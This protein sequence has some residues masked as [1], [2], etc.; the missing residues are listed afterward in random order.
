MQS[1]SSDSEPMLEK[2]KFNLYSALYHSIMA[3]NLI[4]DEEEQEGANEINV[5][6]DSEDLPQ[7]VKYKFSVL[8][9]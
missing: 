1:A 9:M 8:C 4:L 2:Q 6:G 3:N 7:E 5:E